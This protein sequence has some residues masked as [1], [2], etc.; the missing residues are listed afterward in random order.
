MQDLYDM[1]QSRTFL[2]QLGYGLLKIG[3]VSLMPELRPLFRTIERAPV[4]TNI[5]AGITHNSIQSLQSLLERIK[6]VLIS[7]YYSYQ[8]RQI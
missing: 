1:M 7:C 5:Q 3:L 2:Q 6:G 8:G 4:E